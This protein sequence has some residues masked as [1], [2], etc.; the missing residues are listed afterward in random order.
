MEVFSMVEQNIWRNY[1]IKLLGGGLLLIGIII[2]AA[3]LSH[4][5]HQPTAKKE[6]ELAIEPRSD[7]TVLTT[8][9][10]TDFNANQTKSITTIEIA[11][12]IAKPN[13]TPPVV[14]NQ[15]VAQPAT[16]QFQQPLTAQQP[17]STQQPTTVPRPIAS[18][19]P[20]T[21]QQLPKQQPVSNP[22]APKLSNS[23]A[24][25]EPTSSVTP[26]TTV[27]VTPLATVNK[28]AKKSTLGNNAVRKT[29][30]TNTVAANKVT[31]P[32]KSKV[33]AKNSPYNEAE[34]H[35]LAKP[36]THFTIQLGGANSSKNIQAFINKHGLQS[37]ATYFQTYNNGKP[38]YVIVYGDY[39]TRAEAQAAIK[40]LPPEVQK[41]HPWVRSLADVHAA[42]QRKLT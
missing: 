41:A 24:N 16:P 34:K 39:K 8:A 36:K 26:E 10:A 25:V 38:W 14:I 35:L 29:E 1:Q 22:V 11:K 27:A 19:Q 28:P 12:P 30:P 17:A 42:I 3:L 37:Q 21:L 13:A 31:P 5:N 20:S 6:V 40:A 32:T 2:I 4:Y 9:P 7:K 33:A 18:Q 23:A 15:S